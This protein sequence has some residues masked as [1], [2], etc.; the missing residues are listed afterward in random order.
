[1]Q[2]CEQY[3]GL[4]RLPGRFVEI[5]SGDLGRL[6]SFVLTDRT[7]TCNNTPALERAMGRSSPQTANWSCRPASAEERRSN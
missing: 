7:C 1:M 6:E 3:A 2:A 5:A 4:A